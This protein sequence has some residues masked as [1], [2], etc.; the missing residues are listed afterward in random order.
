[1][2]EKFQPHTPTPIFGHQKKERER[3]KRERERETEREQEVKSCQIEKFTKE[4]LLRRLEEKTSKNKSFFSCIEKERV[5]EGVQ[6]RRAN[7]R[8]EW[9]NG[10]NGK[11]SENR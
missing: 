6:E 2:R 7:N 5:R 11:L 3:E 4:N 10:R 9:K 8:E 1:M